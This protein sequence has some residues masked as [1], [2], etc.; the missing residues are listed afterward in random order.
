MKN[1]DSYRKKLKKR[2]H[3][4]NSNNHKRNRNRYRDYD[5]ADDDEEDDI[6]DF[7]NNSDM[8][9]RDKKLYDAIKKG[10]LSDQEIQDLIDSDVITENLV[11]KFLHNVQTEHFENPLTRKLRIVG[12]DMSIEPFTGGM[13]A[14]Y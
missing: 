11:E 10:K 5:D 4:H 3:C 9:P 6:E 12:T 14:S 2:G 7:E 1:S 13:Y 8:T